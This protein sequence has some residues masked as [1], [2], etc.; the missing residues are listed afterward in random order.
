METR[1]FTTKQV[2]LLENSA[3]KNSVLLAFLEKAVVSRFHLK[4]EPSICGY[5]SN[6]STGLLG[7]KKETSNE[8]LLI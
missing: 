4:E 1:C 3:L 6:L 8:M 2:K 7:G 5:Y